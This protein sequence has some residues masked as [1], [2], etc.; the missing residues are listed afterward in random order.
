MS[1][2]RMNNDLVNQ[3]VLDLPFFLFICCSPFQ[4]FLTANLDLQLL[5]IVAVAIAVCSGGILGMFRIMGVGVVPWGHVVL[6]DLLL[7][8]TRFSMNGHNLF[9]CAAQIIMSSNQRPWHITNIF[10]GYIQPL[11]AC[12]HLLECYGGMWNQ[13]FDLLNHS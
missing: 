5:A 2:H 1:V 12:T 7:C 8:C 9:K 4:S 10:C 3:L 11:E 6:I 13:Y